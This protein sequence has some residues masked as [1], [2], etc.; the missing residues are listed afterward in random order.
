MN[1]IVARVFN[2]DFIYFD[3]LFCLIWIGV[4]LKKKHYREFFF[5]LFGFLVVFFTDDVIWFHLKGT[6][7]IDAPLQPDLFLLYFSFTYGVI[8]FSYAIIMIRTKEVKKA[9]FWTVFL[10]VGWLTSAFMSQYIPLDDRTIS[11]YREMT[12]ARLT[13]ILMVG[14]GYLV[15]LL[16]KLFYE[17]MK[18]LS[19]LK[20]AYL[21]LI[22]ILV[23]FGMELT[24]H[25]SGIRP[26]E[27]SLSIILFNSLLEFNSGIPVLYLLNFIIDQRKNNKKLIEVP[28]I[29][30]N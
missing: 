30:S 4:L 15:I 5:G 2:F 3:L 27:G 29:S 25:V 22:G 28:V 24:L 18:D 1:N 26:I 19:F 17:P 10:Y 11:I 16:L 23:H 21:F 20:I 13:Q 12:N 14:I 6:R 9:L 7:V 8:E